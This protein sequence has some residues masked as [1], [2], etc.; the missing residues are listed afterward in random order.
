[1]RRDVE[2]PAAL[3]ETALGGR[4]R[5][6]MDAKRGGERQAVLAPP[7]AG[8]RGLACRCDEFVCEC[9]RACGC[10]LL[11]DGGRRLA[12]DGTVVAATATAPGK[13]HAPGYTFRC[14]CRFAVDRSSRD[15]D[16]M[17]CSCGSGAAG[18]SPCRCRRRCVCD[19]Q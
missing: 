15:F 19:E 6:E 16:S 10:A 1:M 4:R 9:D 14:D 18:A 3:L 5:S 17:A 7:R 8:S 13:S 2:P 11:G 12:D